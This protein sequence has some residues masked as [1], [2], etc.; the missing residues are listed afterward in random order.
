[1]DFNNK[2]NKSTIFLPKLLIIL[3]I[4]AITT[5]SMLAQP[6]I[7]PVKSHLDLPQR[8]IV[9]K[10][11][12]TPKINEPSTKKTDIKNNGKKVSYITIEN[13]DSWN[14]DKEINEDAQLLVGNVAF[15]HEGVNLYCDSA[16]FY[17]KTN[18]F[19]AFGNIV[20]NQGDTL[21]VYGDRLYYDGN[22][23]LAKLRE[24]VLMDNLTATL[25]TDS[26]NYDRAENV[27]YYFNGGIIEDTL[28]MLESETGHYY[29]NSNIAVFHKQ[30]K[31][32]NPNFTMDSDTLRY[33]TKTNIAS[34]VGAT[35]IIYAKATKIY[36][37]KGWYNTK[38]EQ[39]K[40]LLNS[41]IQHDNSKRLEADTIFYDKASGKGEGFSNVK[42][43]DTIKKISLCGNYGYY[44]EKGEK[45]VVTDS[46]VMIDYSSSDSLFL[47]ADTLRTFLLPYIVSDS[48]RT[49]KDSTY[50]VF[51]GYWNVRFYKKDIQGVADSS[52]FNTKDSIMILAPNPI[53]WS[54]KQQVSGDTISVYQQKQKLN[55][56]IVSEK[57]FAIDS[58]GKEYYNQLSGKK[59][60]SHI[61]NDTL[62]RVDV[63]GN[64]ES[65][66]FLQDSKDS[67]IIGVA[68]TVSSIMNIYFG[69]NDDIDRIVVK[70]KPTSNITPISQIDNSKIRLENFHWQSAIRPK[71][72]MDIY[73]QT[74]DIVVRTDSPED[75][76]QKKRNRKTRRESD[77]NKKS[78]TKS[79][80]TNSNSM[81][82]PSGFG[83]PQMFEQ[84]NNKYQL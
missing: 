6:N 71:S 46:A 26:L 59:I 52:Y 48:V 35:D 27:G 19:D 43:T 60:V 42:L 16:L 76:N 51:E 66:Y 50:K 72:K 83:N 68:N 44:L 65:I 47:H 79:L 82:R 81:S 18:S 1:M 39:S 70:P 63:I 56:V 13:A 37:E 29:P 58:V 78:D 21:F 41:Y 9:K 40:L 77:K 80:P 49:L 33:N 14:Y 31:L 32:I 3:I 69:K 5:G 12:K 84:K 25:R 17:E 45:G 55:Q 7:K 62:K 67:T 75:Q 74:K 23:K 8:Q 34:I 53:I 30:V 61:T 4:T 38:N 10:S 15:S 36:S 24:N 64:A 54:G 57:A 73:R 11:S 20:I 2:N 28:N 22:K